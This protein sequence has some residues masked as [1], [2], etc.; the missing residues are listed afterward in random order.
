MTALRDVFGVPPLTQSDDIRRPFP[1]AATA[2]FVPTKPNWN[3]CPCPSSELRS[4]DSGVQPLGAQPVA[5]NR[6]PSCFLCHKGCL[7]T[8]LAGKSLD[9]QWV[10]Y[11]S[12]GFSRQRCQML[13]VHQTCALCCNGSLAREMQLDQPRCL[14]VNCMVTLEDAGG[15]YGSAINEEIISLP[16][17]Q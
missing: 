6:L 10:I 13:R 17:G 3:V 15:S 4:D 1:S 11:T 5:A 9:F 16:H 12:C 2:D 7:V 8:S 14:M